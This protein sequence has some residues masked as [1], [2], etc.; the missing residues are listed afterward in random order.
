MSKI[1]IINE[2][3]DTIL[4]NTNELLGNIQRMCKQNL[5]DL[6]EILQKYNILLQTCE[7][8]ISKED[9]EEIEKELDTSLVIQFPRQEFKEIDKFY[10]FDF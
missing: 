8:A 6:N 10:K 4:N 9:M 1:K 7:N 2:C 3:Q 5:S